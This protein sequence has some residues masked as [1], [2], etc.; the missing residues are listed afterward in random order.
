VVRAHPLT[1]SALPLGACLALAFVGGCK[2]ARPATT[3]ILVDDIDAIERQ[4]ADNAASLQ[5]EGILIAQRPPTATAG[6]PAT[7]ASARA[8]L[9]DPAQPGPELTVD[10]DDAID[11]APPE[12]AMDA[13]ASARESVRVTSREKRTDRSYEKRARSR[14]E[15]ICDLA[16]ATCDLAE[17][18]CSLADRHAGDERY[19]SACSRAADQCR[20]ASTAC[21]RCED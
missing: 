18:V 3:P 17:H 2:P 8:E 1:A 6:P 5:S 21:T 9:P 7:D 15:R 10:D 20:M 14:C 16:E 11:E 12:P 4:L 13:P 19:Q